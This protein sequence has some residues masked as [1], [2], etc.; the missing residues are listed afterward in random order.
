MFALVRTIIYASLF[1]SLVLIYVPAQLL[2]GS[3]IIRPEIGPQQIIAMVIGLFGAVIALWCIFTFAIIG[4]GTPAPFDPPR[5]LV[6]NGPYHYVR[7]P[8]YIGAG[9]SLAGA[10]LFFESWPVLVY[11]GVLFLITHLL[12]VFYEEPTLRETF[13]KD[14]E[15]YCI[16][17][18]RWLPRIGNSKLDE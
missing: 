12:I 9:L 1:I 2:S 17:V 16:K 8:M 18:N 7:N 15:T 11:T 4:K 14:Y 13:G 3:G 5:R 6:I 10:A